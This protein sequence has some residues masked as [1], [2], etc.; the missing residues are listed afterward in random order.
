MGVLEGPGGGEAG[1]ATADYGDSPPGVTCQQGTLAWTCGKPT[2][3]DEPWGS[4]ETSK[5][6]GKDEEVTY[7]R[8][9]GVSNTSDKMGSG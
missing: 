8:L 3:D 2:V 9:A 4:A 7:T 6:L 5:R 1:A